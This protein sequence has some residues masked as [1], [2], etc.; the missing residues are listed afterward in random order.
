MEFARAVSVSDANADGHAE[1]DHEHESRG[2]GSDGDLMG[3]ERF[4]ADPAHH[5]RGEGEG[6]DF[7]QML[8]ANGSAEGDELFQAREMEAS[9]PVRRQERFKVRISRQ[10]NEHDNCDDNASKEGG[11]A[12]AFE[13]ES[14]CAEISK[15]Q[16]PIEENIQEHA[17]EQNEVWRPGMVERFAELFRGVREERGDDRPSANQEVSA[18]FGDHFR[19]LTEAVEMWNEHVASDG[20]KKPE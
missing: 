16:N 18:G 1:A 13:T 8:Q 2:G 3:G 7:E 15:N 11:P 6:A 5:E 14:G 17:C 19:V 4:G 12:G 9:N 10:I 20:E